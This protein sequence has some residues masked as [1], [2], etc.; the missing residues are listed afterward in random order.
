[1]K[2]STRFILLLLIILCVLAVFLYSLNDRTVEQAREEAASGAS[3]AFNLLSIDK[4]K[5]PSLLITDR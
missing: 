4:E 5:R 1:M 3:E 2:F